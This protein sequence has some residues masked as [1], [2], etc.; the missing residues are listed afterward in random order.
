MT[1]PAAG[2]DP[3][4]L[5]YRALVLQCSHPGSVDEPNELV[6][7]LWTDDHTAVVAGMTRAEREDLWADLEALA[8]RLDPWITHQA[9]PTQPA[10]ANGTAA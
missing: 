6:M 4:Q 2:L 8:E 10:A 9:K 7:A 1:G 5:H 3:V